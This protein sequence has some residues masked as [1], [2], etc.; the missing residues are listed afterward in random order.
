[1]RL[2]RLRMSSRLTQEEVAEAMNVS[3]SAVAMW[4]TGKS[5]PKS[6]QLLSLAKLYKCTIDALLSKEPTTPTDQVI[7]TDVE[8]VR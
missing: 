5:F 7:Q 6:C 8:V 1:M 3:R 4:E 2:K